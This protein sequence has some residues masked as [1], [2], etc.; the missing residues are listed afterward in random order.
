MS[1]EG[2]AKREQARPEGASSRERQA[3]SRWAAAGARSAEDHEQPVVV[4]QLRHLR[5]VPLRTMVNWPHSP[6]GSPS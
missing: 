5:Q 2:F 3:V 4:P 6:Q 1:V